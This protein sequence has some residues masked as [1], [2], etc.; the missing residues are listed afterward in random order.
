MSFIG[1]WSYYQFDNWTYQPSYV[2]SNTPW[3]FNGVRIPI[4]P[5]EKLKIEPWIVKGWQSYGKFN[6]APGGGGQIVWRP[7]GSFSLVANNYFGTDTL[8]TPDR[9]R[10]HT[11][12]SIQVKYLD[13][14]ASVLSKAAM[15]LTVDAGC[16]WA[17]GVSCSGAPGRP[18]QYFLGLMAYD[19]M[20]FHHDKYAVTLG[21]GAITNPGRYLVLIPPINGVTAF[22]GS[23]YF[24]A[25]PGGKYKAWDASATVDYTPSQ[26]LTWRVEYNHRAS[27]VPY[28]SGAGGITPPGGNAGSLGSFVPGWSPDLRKYENRFTIALLLKL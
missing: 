14:P 6:K 27:N 19:R 16:E 7:N 10:F 15:T 5:S 22:T 26:F 11:D 17:G 24:T 13:R 25:S 20:W 23:P 9:K 8:G 2:S 1:L 12:D 3:F 18:A 28:F 21:G 4:F